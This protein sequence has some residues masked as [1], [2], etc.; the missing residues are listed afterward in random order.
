MNRWIRRKCNSRGYGVQSPND[1]FFVQHVLRERSP[2]YAYASLHELY[3]SVKVS[4][5][6]AQL[7]S[8]EAYRLL[9]RVADY[10]RP[11]V[12]VTVA[13]EAGLA[14]CSMAM[15][16]PS[17]RCVSICAEGTAAHP[18]PASSE[19]KK[20]DEMA[21][22]GEELHRCD[23]AR[24]LY[25]GSTPHYQELVQ[26]ALEHV[27]DKTVL[28]IDALR[29]NRAKRLWWQSLCQSPLTGVSYDLGTMGLL[30]FD[31]ARYKHAYLIDIRKKRFP[32]RI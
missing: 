18:I 23:E 7:S 31:T 24:L 16:R 32:H 21:L 15:A 13:D 28:I 30:F 3:R 5:P 17:Q 1:F 20:G 29:A 26:I 2:Y 6:H 9:F 22:F 19:V 4:Q 12:L 25:I 14:T 10:A 27:C 8:E 11:E